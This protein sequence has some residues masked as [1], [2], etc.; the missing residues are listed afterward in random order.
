VRS[1]VVENGV[2]ER[3]GRGDGEE[4]VGTIIRM[5]GAAVGGV[6]VESAERGELVLEII[7]KMR[8]IA[9]RGKFERKEIPFN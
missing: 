8:K 2:E 9:Q 5:T 7:K 1:E 4:A 3:R 6:D